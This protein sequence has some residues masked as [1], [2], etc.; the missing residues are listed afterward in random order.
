MAIIKPITTQMTL[1]QRIYLPK[2]K[3]FS[4]KSDVILH[5]CKFLAC[6]AE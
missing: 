5:I 1:L 3:K 2:Q 6:L 4:E